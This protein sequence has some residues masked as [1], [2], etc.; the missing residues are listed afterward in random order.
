MIHLAC[1][2]L[3]ST[4][5]LYFNRD[6]IYV[7]TL[8]WEETYDYQGQSHQE[9]SFGHTTKEASMTSEEITETGSDLEWTVVLGE[10]ISCNFKI[11]SIS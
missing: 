1:L 7:P 8:D 9:W 3:I 10:C 5:L 11:N 6:Q 2:C 4:S